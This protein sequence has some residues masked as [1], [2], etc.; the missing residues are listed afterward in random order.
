MEGR[1]HVQES[2]E[3]Q[4]MGW[5]PGGGASP[6]LSTR[7]RRLKY[8]A[9][10]IIIHMH[11]LVQPGILQWEIECM[12]KNRTPMGEGGGGALPHPPLFDLSY[13]GRRLIIRGVTHR[14]CIGVARILAIE[15]RMHIYT[16]QQLSHIRTDGGGGVLINCRTHPS[17][18]D[19]R[20]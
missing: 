17:F 15:L 5:G 7:G 11:A 9:Y 19:S 10:L 1:R 16:K 14:L 3:P 20:S 13:H 8:V 18:I 12:Y 2:T 6:H 4:R